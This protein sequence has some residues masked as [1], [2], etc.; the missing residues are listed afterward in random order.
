MN[1][2][3]KTCNKDC[4]ECRYLNTK[5]DDKYYPYGHECMKY[6]DSVFQEEFN[7]TKIFKVYRQSR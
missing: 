1:V 4:R 5:V 2:T 3:E 7:T 6:G